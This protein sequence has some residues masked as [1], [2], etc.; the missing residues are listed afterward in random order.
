M[1]ESLDR[2]ISLVKTVGGLE[3]KMDSLMV[4]NTSIH[5]EVAAMRAE[6]TAHGVAIER[7]TDF[8]TR[9]RAVERMIWKA[10]GIAGAAGAG[11]GLLLKLVADLLGG[12]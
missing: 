2:E 10:A 3:A 9:L 6:V 8:E 5:S 4:T 11:G 12:Y 1:S 7:I